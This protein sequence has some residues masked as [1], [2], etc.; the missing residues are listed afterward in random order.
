[1]VRGLTA[2]SPQK[3]AQEPLRCQDTG[4]EREGRSTDIRAINAN[5]VWGRKLR[6]E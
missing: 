2:I 1:M 4:Q 5:L 6:T 3:G